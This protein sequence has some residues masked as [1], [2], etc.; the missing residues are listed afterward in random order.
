MG[1]HFLVEHGRIMSRHRIL[2]CPSQPWDTWLDDK[3]ERAIRSNRMLPKSTL[4]FSRI[5]P[6]PHHIYMH[7]RR[8]RD[9]GFGVREVEKCLQGAP[10]P[11]RRWWSRATSRYDREE[12][13]LATT[14]QWGFV[15]TRILRGRSAGGDASKSRLRGGNKLWMLWWQR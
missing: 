3:R 13:K 15:C 9:S 6:L 7:L 4:L 12:T 10:S 1:S 8:N 11:P 2:G 14:A 5:L